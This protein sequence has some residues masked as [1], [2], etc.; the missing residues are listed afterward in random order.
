[1]TS[2][3]FLSVVV[4]VYNEEKVIAETLRKLT[5]FLEL[6]GY[7]WEIVVA[8]DGSTDATKT[9]VQRVA[10]SRPDGRIQLVDLVQNT[11]KGAAIRQG[12]L[13]AA[14]RY[15]LFSDADLSTPIKEVDKLLAAL[16]SGADI[17]IAS[18]V[19]SKKENTVQQSAKR[20]IAGRIFNGL[21]RVITGL[22]F[23]DTQCGFKCFKREA[24]MRIFQN[25]TLN[26]FGFDVEV[27]L[28]AEK[29]RYKVVE[30]PVMWKQGLYSKVR[31]YHDSI[32][33]IGEMF[34]LR[35]KYLSGQS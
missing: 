17:A 10:Q 30:V 4:P 20:A 16:E 28:L 15:L 3:V 29:F 6:K 14:G 19:D 12:M 27:L 23:K 11:G 26:R 22:S 2:E 21:V 34:Y 31:L 33:M 1:M 32:A 5:V 8:S 24:A 7:S 13:K 25:L 18:R 35:R 9:I